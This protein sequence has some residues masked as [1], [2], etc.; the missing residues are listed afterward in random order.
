MSAI[1]NRKKSIFEKLCPLWVFLGMALHIAAVWYV[2]LYKA[3]S[4]DTAYNYTTYIRYIIWI[5]I[6]VVST[7]S[8]VPESITAIVKHLMTALLSA[9]V[10]IMALYYYAQEFFSYSNSVNWML[11]T[12]SMSFDE[13]MSVLSEQ[14]KES[15]VK[16]TF[17][18]AVRYSLYLCGAVTAFAAIKYHMSS[19]GWIKKHIK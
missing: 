4:Y 17:I 2:S 1:M 7:W 3:D 11:I 18:Y 8:F 16:L 12:N 13:L 5:A 6:V 14:T 19:T 10:C 15:Y 9:A